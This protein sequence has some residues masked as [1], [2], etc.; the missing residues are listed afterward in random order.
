CPGQS[1]Q[2]GHAFGCFGSPACRTITENGVAAGAITKGTPA[3]AT[4]ASVFCIAAT[5]N[6]LVDASADLAGPR[7]VSPRG[8]FL[9]SDGATAPTS[10]AIAPA[11][12][13]TVPPQTTTTMPPSTTL[14]F[15]LTAGGSN[16]GNTKDVSN[17]VIKN[18]AC[19]GL[20]IGAGASLIPEGP[21]PDGSVSRF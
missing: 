21:T 13:T 10:T 12:P 17:T 2:M 14:D 18:L 20:S 3:S 4:L 7:P 15:V 6:G 1:D 5:G 19:G 11:A 16:C 8:M 9:V